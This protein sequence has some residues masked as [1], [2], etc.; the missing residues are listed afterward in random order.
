MTREERQ[1]SDDERQR[2]RA[3]GAEENQWVRARILKQDPPPEGL[4]QA[5]ERAC[6]MAANSFGVHDPIY[7]EALVNRAL[8][9]DV[10]ENDEAKAAAC[11]V[12]ARTVLVE[13]SV[14]MATGLYLLGLFHFQTRHDV[15]KAERLVAQALAMFTQCLGDG[16][17]PVADCL[18]M[19]AHIRSQST[20]GEAGET[21]RRKQPP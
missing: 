10:T 18:N 16:S 12:E 9:Y 4:L 13:N 19:L 21:L 2:L 8:Y 5:V 11:F 1:I 20:Q 6:R 15:E 3:F 17:R 14:E 7:G